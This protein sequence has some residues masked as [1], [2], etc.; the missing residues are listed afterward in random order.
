MSVKINLIYKYVHY[1]SLNDP[2]ELPYGMLKYQIIQC[3]KK[4][5]SYYR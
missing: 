3:L 1:K 2:I 4:H 5:E